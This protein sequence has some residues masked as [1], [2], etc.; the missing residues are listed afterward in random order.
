VNYYEDS[1]YADQHGAQAWAGVP[2]DGLQRLHLTLP[3]S[4]HALKQRSVASYTSQLMRLG[5]GP[6]N[7][8][9]CDAF[10]T[11]LAAESYWRRLHPGSPAHQHSRRM[12]IDQN[13]MCLLDV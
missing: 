11:R 4:G 8:V 2:I 12:T 9:D 5:V 6:T 10:V 3:P 13:F 1:L 7:P